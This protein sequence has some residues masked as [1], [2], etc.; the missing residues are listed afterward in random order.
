MPKDESTPGVHRNFCHQQSIH[1]LVWV[2]FD[3]HELIWSLQESTGFGVNA[4]TA[5]PCGS[6]L[7]CPSQHP[8]KKC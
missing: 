4:K 2:S 7:I 6:G 3:W 1:L 5:G 8:V